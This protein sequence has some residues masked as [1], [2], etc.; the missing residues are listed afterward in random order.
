[1]TME[2]MNTVSDRGIFTGAKGYLVGEV[3]DRHHYKCRGKKHHEPPTRR[4]SRKSTSATTAKITEGFK[5]YKCAIQA[6]RA[7][8]NA[9]KESTTWQNLKM[10]LV[11]RRLR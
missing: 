8:K 5:L 4:S 11:Q 7:Q 9:V 2:G 1:M 3:D 10:V 6:G